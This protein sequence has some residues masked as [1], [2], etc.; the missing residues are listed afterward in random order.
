[1][2]CSHPQF[3]RRLC[4]SLSRTC[5]QR[6]HQYQEQE[7]RQPQ[8]AAALGCL[9]MPDT[10][11]EQLLSGVADCPHVDDGPVRQHI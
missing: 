4:N 1:M 5:S 10:L 11:P 9:E 6:Q 7:W 3:S 8:R 2:H